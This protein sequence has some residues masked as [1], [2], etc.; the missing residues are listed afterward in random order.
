MPIFMDR[1]D[2]PGG[3]AE[4]VA[5]AHR[6]DLQ[7]QDQ[8][9]VRFLTYWFDDRRGTTFCLVDAPDM[10][11]VKCVHREAHGHIPGEVVEVSLSAVEAFLGRVSDPRGESRPVSEPA[12]RA[13]MFTDIVGSTALTERLGDAMTTELVR[14]HDAI[15]RRSL[16]RFEGT[17]VKHTGDGI[18]ASFPSSSRGIDAAIAIQREFASYNQQAHEHLHIRIGIACGQPVE[19][20]ND[21]F[22][23]TVQMAARLCS[24]AAPDQIIASGD[25]ASEDGRAELFVRPTEQVLKGFAVPVL[26]YECSW[27]T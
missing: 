18:M 12:H 27:W 17:E 16:N 23:R 26:S 7:L 20:S 22:G 25:A 3:T 11:S 19:D 14:A 13:V 10:D 4:D 24:A 9:G 8:Y 21:L 6:K 2:I 15:V 5:D 1:H